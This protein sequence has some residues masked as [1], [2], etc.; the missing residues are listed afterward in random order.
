MICGIAD[1]ECV[2]YQGCRIC[3]LYKTELNILCYLFLLVANLEHCLEGDDVTTRCG[4]T[5]GSKNEGADDRCVIAVVAVFDNFFTNIT[6]MI[7]VGVNVCVAGGNVIITCY[8]A[9]CNE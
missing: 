8:K 4:C 6:N 5:A 1:L 9:H 2:S 7:A 3:A